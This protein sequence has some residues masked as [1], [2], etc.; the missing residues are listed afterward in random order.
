MTGHLLPNLLLA[1][2]PKAGTT[3]LF[4]Y[5][6]Q[7]PGVC[8][9][10]DKEVD[11]FTPL[12]QPGAQLPPLDRYAANY[13]DCVGADYVLDGSPSYAVG[14]SPVVE[15]IRSALGDPHVIL[16]LREPCARFWS[17]YT[18]LRAQGYLDTVADVDEFL[19]RCIEA[20]ADGR[21]RLLGNRLQALTTGCYADYLGDWI[22]GFG[23]RVAV[24][25]AED[26]AADPEAV[27]ERLFRW[28]GLD[29]APAGDADL[30]R[31]NRTSHARS[32]AVA[33]FARG[34]DRSLGAV[35]ERAPVLR[36]GL[37]RAYHALNSRPVAES[38][39]PATRARLERLY[40]D[41]NRRTA[42][43]LR[44]HGVGP[45]PDWLATA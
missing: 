30:T 32:P 39:P 38:L 42:A 27:V 24:V 13:A 7:H 14:G 45:L 34:A 3:S 21:D 31:R 44:A 25:F 40:E 23:E 26:L 2:V 5:L 17:S 4:Q 20:R 28:L 15:G 12:R 19:E 6:V 35:L 33:A 37:R 36:R 16:S 29:P 43:L 41:S 9:G 11:Y 18:F 22:E 1:G 8:G 10:A